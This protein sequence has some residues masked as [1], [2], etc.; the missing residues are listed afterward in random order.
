MNPNFDVCILW[1]QYQRGMLANYGERQVLGEDLTD[2]LRKIDQLEV[3]QRAH[4][5]ERVHDASRPQADV[6]RSSLYRA[7]TAVYLPNTPDGPQVETPLAAY[8]NR[9]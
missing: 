6:D 2:I 9:R 5:V 7:A 4:S 8:S 1:R 3:G